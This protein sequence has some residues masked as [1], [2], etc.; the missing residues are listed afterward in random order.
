MR[1]EELVF[2]ALCLFWGA[3]AL[4]LRREF[5]ALASEGGR[6]LRDIRLLKPLLLVAAAAL[7]ASGLFLVLRSL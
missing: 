3:A 1:I 7:L 5:Y 6:G 2:G 4:A